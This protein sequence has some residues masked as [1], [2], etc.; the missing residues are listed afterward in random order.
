MNGFPDGVWSD[1]KKDEKLQM[2]ARREKLVNILKALEE[3]E[4]KLC[5]VHAWQVDLLENKNAA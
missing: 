4:E 3:E 1:A 5:D 2:T